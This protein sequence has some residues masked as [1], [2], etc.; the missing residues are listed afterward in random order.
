MKNNNKN[1]IN[2]TN[3]NKHEKF[4]EKSATSTKQSQECDLNIKE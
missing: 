1:I 2:N 4:K 3:I